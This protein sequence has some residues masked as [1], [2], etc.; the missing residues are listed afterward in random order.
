MP[1]GERIEHQPLAHQPQGRSFLVEVTARI[2]LGADVPDCGITCNGYM[3]QPTKPTIE[4]TNLVK[5][6]GNTRILDHISFAA[7]PGRI[8][9]VVGENGAGKS[10]TFRVL[11]GLDRA[12]SGSATI[13]GKAYA[14]LANPM[15]HIGAVLDG[16]GAHPKRSAANHLRWIAASQGLPASRVSE[17]LDFVGLADA[18]N[19][20]VGGFSLGM[21][22]RLSLAAAMLGDPDVLVLDEPMN[23]L[24]P[25]AIRFLR[26]LM[27]RWADEGRTVVV[28]S[29]L[30]DELAGVADDIVVIAGGKVIANGPVAV[31]QGEHPSLEA[32]YFAITDQQAGW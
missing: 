26:E 19:Q 9:G 14:E 20:T 11:L 17:V 5:D 16:P 25:R 23:G 15:T 8:T 29:H 1:W 4:I 12:T 27:R 6:R 28:S 3:T 18:A 7:Y 22:Q 31:V 24:D 21:T 13:R 10:S 30:I 2:S 32:A